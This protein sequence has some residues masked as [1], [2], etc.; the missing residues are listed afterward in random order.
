[1]S[2]K[3]RQARAV[4]RA[5]RTYTGVDYPQM[6]LMRL[7]DPDEWVAYVVVVR[8]QGSTIVDWATAGY[9]ASKGA[10]RVD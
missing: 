3:G 6:T 2:R 7:I 10:K 1:M 4:A 5:I 9:L 8:G